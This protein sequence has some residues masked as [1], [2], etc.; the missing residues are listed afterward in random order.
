VLIGLRRAGIDHR[1]QSPGGHHGFKA[2][3]EAGVEVGVDGE[4]RV[5]EGQ[6]RFGRS[7]PTGHRLLRIAVH[8]AKEIEW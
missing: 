3:C 4:L 2:A 5:N 8:C 7:H 6:R 1:A